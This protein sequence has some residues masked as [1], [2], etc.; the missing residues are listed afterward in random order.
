MPEPIPV[1]IPAPVLLKEFAAGLPY[2]GVQTH[3]TWQSVPEG[4]E[5]PKV[6]GVPPVDYPF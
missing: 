4:Y 3:F 6:R 2:A 5:V 1:P